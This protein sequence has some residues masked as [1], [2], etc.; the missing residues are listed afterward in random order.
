MVAENV[1]LFDLVSLQMR[2]KL[3]KSSVNTSLQSV[4]YKKAFWL[5]FKI[6]IEYFN[7]YGWNFIIEGIQILTSTNFPNTL[8]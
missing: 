3:G 8:N 2:E 5:F 6:L 7:D 1:V 4:K